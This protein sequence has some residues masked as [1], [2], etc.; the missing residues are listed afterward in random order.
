MQPIGTRRAETFPA[1]SHPT[2][3]AFAPGCIWNEPS[4][5]SDTHGMESRAGRK[6]YVAHQGLCPDTADRG[7]RHLGPGAIHTVG[8]SVL[9]VDGRLFFAAPKLEADRRAGLDPAADAGR[10]ARGCA[11]LQLVQHHV[12]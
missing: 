7:L 9:A 8:Q 1:M 2:Y 11:V 6:R 12:Q 4:R 3:N 10:R 5:K